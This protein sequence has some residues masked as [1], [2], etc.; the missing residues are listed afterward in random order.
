MC[1][2]FPIIRYKTIR[3]IYLFFVLIMSTHVKE[4]ETCYLISLNWVFGN[5]LK[6]WCF[7]LSFYTTVLAGKQIA[8]KNFDW[9]ICC[10]PFSCFHLF[11][12]IKHIN[13]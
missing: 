4:Y 7:I 10:Y 3:D 5:V 2:L 11:S 1:S 13:I 6:I 9:S 8:K 12:F